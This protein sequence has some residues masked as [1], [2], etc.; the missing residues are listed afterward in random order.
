MFLATTFTP[1]RAGLIGSNEPSLESA[2]SPPT[3]NE[4]VLE[5]RRRNLQQQSR[6][7]RQ[8]SVP[9][10]RRVVSDIGAVTAQLSGPTN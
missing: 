2:A 5:V 1:D 10:V 8:Q 7:L 6:N 9:V 3:T 4:L